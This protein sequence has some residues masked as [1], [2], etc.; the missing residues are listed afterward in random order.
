MEVLVFGALRV[1][2]VPMWARRS[3]GAVA[4]KVVKCSL[5]MYKAWLCTAGLRYSSAP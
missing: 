2:G 1:K 4:Y 3:F 5:Q